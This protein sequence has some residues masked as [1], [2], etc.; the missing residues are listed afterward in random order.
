MLGGSVGAL[1]AG[2]LADSFG[3]QRVFLLWLVPWLTAAM[4][5]HL[6]PQPVP[7]LPAESLPDRETDP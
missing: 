5:Y 3:L 1:A 7:A 4:F 6:R 2:R